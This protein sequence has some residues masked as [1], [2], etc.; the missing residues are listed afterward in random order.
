MNNSTLRT[1]SSF[2]EIADLDFSLCHGPYF[3]C[4]YCTPNRR[5]GA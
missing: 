3:Y 2:D 1:V 5:I 4:R